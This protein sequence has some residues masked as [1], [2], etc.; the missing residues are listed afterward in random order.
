MNV[1]ETPLR[2]KLA[3]MSDHSLEEI[4]ENV[5]T[6][7][8]IRDSDRYFKNVDGSDSCLSI[9][10]NRSNGGRFDIVAAVMHVRLTFEGTT[11]IHTLDAKTGRAA[12]MTFAKL[13]DELERVEAGS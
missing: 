9:E 12:L 7:M 3:A 10:P 2:E 11:M 1:K 8:E 5:Q 4:L 6:E 13:V